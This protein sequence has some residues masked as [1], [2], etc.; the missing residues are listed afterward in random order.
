MLIQKTNIFLDTKALTITS[1]QGQESQWAAKKNLSIH[2]IVL[3]HSYL[4]VNGDQ[5][6]KH[7]IVNI[8]FILYYSRVL[9]LKKNT[10]KVQI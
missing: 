8:Y 2:H 3:I 6:N 9:A 10:K 1:C 5:E 7:T 4:D